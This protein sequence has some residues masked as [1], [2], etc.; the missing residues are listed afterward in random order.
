M[1]DWGSLA[2]RLTRASGPDSG[3]DGEI[4]RT[5]GV[6]QQGYTGSVDA[7]RALVASLLPGWHLH[8][9]FDVGGVLPYAA[10]NRD[11]RHWEATAPT[12]PLAILRAAVAV[13]AG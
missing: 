12:V 5:L 9:G 11:D 10:L 8:V 4:A 7:A 2:D 3:L 6:A 1:A 13:L